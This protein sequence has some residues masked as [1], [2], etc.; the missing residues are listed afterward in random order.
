[1]LMEKYNR[2]GHR[3]FSRALHW[4]KKGMNFKVCKIWGGLCTQEGALW[5]PTNCAAAG[6]TTLQWSLCF[7]MPVL[8]H[9]ASKDIVCKDP[10]LRAAPEEPWWCAYDTLGQHCGQNSTFSNRARLELG[11]K[12]ALLLFAGDCYVKEGMPSIMQDQYNQDLFQ[13]GV[14]SII[15]ICPIQHWSTI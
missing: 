15:F 10:L 4:G 14:P 3:L 7:L 8:H 6:K 5:Y 2:A 13:E 11:I 12:C 1:M 9:C